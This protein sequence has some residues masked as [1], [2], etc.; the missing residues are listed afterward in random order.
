ME[1]KH[2]GSFRVKPNTQLLRLRRHTSHKRV[3][4]KSSF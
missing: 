4:W 1:R 2:R 3:R